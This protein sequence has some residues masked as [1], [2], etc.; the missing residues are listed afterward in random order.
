[1]FLSYNKL[2][3]NRQMTHKQ[4][5][6]KMERD[7]CKAPDNLKHYNLSE[8]NIETLLRKCEPLEKE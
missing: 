6:R 2:Q 5:Y 8:G 7:G 1:M 4:M 3:L